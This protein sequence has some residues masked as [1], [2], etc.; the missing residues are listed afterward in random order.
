MNVLVLSMDSIAC[1]Y[2]DSATIDDGTCTY[3]DNYPDNIY[4]C[5]GDCC[6]VS[7]PECAFTYIMN[8]AGECNGSA[9]EDVCGTCE[10]TCDGFSWK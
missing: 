2:D 10:G 5:N 3:P 8:C 7:Q 9:E 6:N 4:D 1:N